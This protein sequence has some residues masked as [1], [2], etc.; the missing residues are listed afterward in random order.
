MRFAIFSIVFAFFF[1]VANAAPSGLS[2]TPAVVK[3]EGKNI[4]LP[5]PTQEKTAQVYFFN[6]ISKKSLWLDH[7]IDKLS[8]SAGWSSYF[9]P[10]NW[11]AMVVN[12]KDFT[13]SCAQIEPGK[14]AYQEC[15]KA[16]AICTPKQVDFDAKRKGSY[17]LVEDKSWDD[18]V[19]AL[20]KH[21]KGT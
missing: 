13:I 3:V 2:C 4:I 20:K 12:R 15:A 17:W 7:P 9:Q 5:G 18:F 8:A 16:I 10:G 11:S 1:N 19:V 21:S 6:N 14:V